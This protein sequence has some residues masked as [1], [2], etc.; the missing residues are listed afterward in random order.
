MYLAIAAIVLLTLAGAYLPF[1]KLRRQA[2]KKRKADIQRA[3][4]G[5]SSTC[6][7]RPCK[8]GLAFNAALGNHAQDVAVGSA[9][10]RNQSGTLGSALGTLRS[11]TRCAPWPIA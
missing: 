11:R 10:R 3:L 4:A 1:S 9:R 8:P 2:A 5:L 6:S 7:R